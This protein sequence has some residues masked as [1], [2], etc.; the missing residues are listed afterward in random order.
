MIIMLVFQN[1]T[2]YAKVNH[3]ELCES[4]SSLF[5]HN[6]LTIYTNTTSWPLMQNLMGFLLQFTEMEY[7]IQS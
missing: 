6:L 1:V 5:Y 2:W 7:Y 3:H 4:I